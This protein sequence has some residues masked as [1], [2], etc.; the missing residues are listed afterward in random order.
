MGRRL[1]VV[2]PAYNAE[3]TL[4]RT[5]PTSPGCVDEI[6]LV[7]DGSRDRTVEVARAWA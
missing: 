5:W 3:A 7:D 1:V 6:I 4:A 2:M